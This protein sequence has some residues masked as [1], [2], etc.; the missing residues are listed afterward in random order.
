MRNSFKVFA[1]ANSFGLTILNILK[2]SF[3]AAKLFFSKFLSILYCK[4]AYDTPLCIRAGLIRFYLRPEIRQI[5][6]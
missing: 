5:F 2:K 1:Q 3:A 4:T 6:L